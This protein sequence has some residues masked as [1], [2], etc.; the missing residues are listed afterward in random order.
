MRSSELLNQLA[1]E[2]IVQ[3]EQ[4]TAKPLRMQRSNCEAE[5][6]TGFEGEEPGTIAGHPKHDV[7]DGMTLIRECQ[8]S[9]FG[10]LS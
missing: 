2:K 6:R 3:S 1:G 4:S 7:L 5:R 9:V 10:N 8:S